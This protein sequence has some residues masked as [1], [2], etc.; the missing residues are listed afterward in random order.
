MKKPVKKFVE[1]LKSYGIFQNI[2]NNPSGMLK[3]IRNDEDFCLFQK[4]I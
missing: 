2:Q 3:S 1:S 4:E